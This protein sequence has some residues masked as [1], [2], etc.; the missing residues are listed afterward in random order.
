MQLASQALQA[1]EGT[2]LQVRRGHTTP[3]I[4]HELSRCLFWRTLHPACHSCPIKSSPTRSF[5]TSA[6]PLGEQCRYSTHT[7]A[8]H[9]RNAP[10]PQL[11]LQTL[12][13]CSPRWH[14]A[15]RMRQGPQTPPHE[16]KLTPARPAPPGGMHGSV[17]P[18]GGDQTGC[19]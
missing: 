9:A 17:A 6:Q 8:R 11:H 15:Q 1:L 16:A 3:G 14:P 19:V 4:A 7:Q 2:V 13:S 10:I 5:T 18:A 12:P